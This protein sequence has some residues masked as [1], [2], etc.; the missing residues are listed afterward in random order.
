MVT[1]QTLE[2]LD[3]DLSRS[4]YCLKCGALFHNKAFA[5][6]HEERC[7]GGMDLNGL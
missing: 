2:E 5:D 3:K 1:E 7:S 4:Y 6:R